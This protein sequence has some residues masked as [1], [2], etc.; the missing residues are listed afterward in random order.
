MP[1]GSYILSLSRCLFV[2][3][4][5]VSTSGMGKTWNV[6]IHHIVARRFS[7]PRFRWPELK[8][9]IFLAKEVAFSRPST[10]LKRRLGWEGKAVKKKV[11]ILV[12]A[13]RL[14]CSTP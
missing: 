9:D 2:N 10:S 11:H 6:F 14:G 1:V 7:R 5:V 12:F 8:Y 13:A 3:R 4:P